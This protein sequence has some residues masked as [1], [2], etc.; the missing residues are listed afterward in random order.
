MVTRGRLDY[1]D[2]WLSGALGNAGGQKICTDN[3]TGAFSFFSPLL[4]FFVL[5]GRLRRE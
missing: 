4:F 2:Y 3:C 1:L 5:A